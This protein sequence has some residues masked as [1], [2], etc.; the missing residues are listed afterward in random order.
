MVFL[1]IVVVLLNK[2]FSFMLR[3]QTTALTVGAGYLAIKNLEPLKTDISNPT[4]LL[5]CVGLVALVISELFV[6]VY[7]EAA[8]TIAVCFLVDKEYGEDDEKC[9][10]ELKSYLE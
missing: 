3:L 8:D 5:V 2:V 10:Y 9:P 6:S 7:L 1:E 4:P